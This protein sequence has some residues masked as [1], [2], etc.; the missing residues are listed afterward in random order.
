M[1]HKPSLC[2]LDFLRVSEVHCTVRLLSEQ[3]VC[4][5]IMERHYLSFDPRWR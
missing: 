1:Q 4:M 2:A 3:F 5:P